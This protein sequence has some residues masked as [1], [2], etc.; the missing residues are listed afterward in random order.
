MR[1]GNRSFALACVCAWLS[2][3]AKQTM[4]A[5]PLALPVWAL[6]TAG[7]RAGVRAGVCVFVTGAVV[8]S[9][10]LLGWAGDGMIFNAVLWPGHLPW[11]GT[12]PGS[13]AGVAAE[14][15]PQALP[16]VIVLLA[17]LGWRSGSNRWML[18]V[19]VGLALVPM[20]ILGRVKKGGDLNSFSPALYPWLLACASRVTQLASEADEFAP[21]WRRWLV[22]GLAGF[23][24]MGIPT[25]LTEA[26]IYTRLRPGQ[27]EHAYLR[28]HPGQVYFPW[29][30]LAHLTA[31]GRLTH[32][33][34]SVWERRAAGYP[35]SRAHTLE[36]I[37]L[38]C[39]YVAFPLKRLGPVVGFSWSFELLEWLGWLEKEATP[40]RLAG[41]PDYECYELRR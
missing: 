37:P 31:E 23:S 11:K 36:G 17:G 27:A 9:V 18:P 25:F 26:K 32:H 29:H 2:V 14:L 10:F 12:A 21:V 13:L 41:L 6:A 30:P 39:R 22:A 4:I 35:V 15:V 5:L 8:S 3:W 16:L 1:D 7:I 24:F 20:A 19:L 33:A 40:V 28:T 34:H 38:E